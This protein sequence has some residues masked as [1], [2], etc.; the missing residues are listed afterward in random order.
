VDDVAAKISELAVI[1]RS[2][3]TV[4]C[5]SLSANINANRAFDFALAIASLC[6]EVRKVRVDKVNIA[7]AIIVKSTNKESVSTNVKPFLRIVKVRIL[8]GQMAIEMVTMAYT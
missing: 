2:G 8:I 6:P 5:K 7:M 3:P 1:A 4:F